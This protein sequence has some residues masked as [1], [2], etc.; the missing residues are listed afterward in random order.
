[1]CTEG[2]TGDWWPCSSH[3]TQCTQW[4]YKSHCAHLRPNLSHPSPLPPS[5][6]LPSRR[7]GRRREAAGG[8]VSLHYGCYPCHLVIQPCRLWSVQGR[9]LGAVPALYPPGFAESTERS[10]AVAVSLQFLQA[11]RGVLNVAGRRFSSSCRLRGACC[12]QLTSL[13]HTIFTHLKLWVALARHNF[14]LVKIEIRSGPSWTRA[15][16][17]SQPRIAHRKLCP[18]LGCR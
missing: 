3:R 6:F 8:G 16:L 4:Q 9:L 1:M 5:S 12:T 11:L 15:D 7:G 18:R 2:P 14:K 10:S 13:G 17:Q